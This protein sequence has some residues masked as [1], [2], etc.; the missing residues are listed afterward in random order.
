MKG[1][2]IA[3]S[4]EGSEHASLSIPV[5]LKQPLSKNSPRMQITERPQTTSYELT[6]AVVMHRANHVPVSTTTALHNARL[7]PCNLH[8]PLSLRIN[9]IVDDHVPLL[10]YTCQTP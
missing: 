2:R 4:L 8:W 7:R 9:A 3:T 6:A 10:L 5:S 1:P